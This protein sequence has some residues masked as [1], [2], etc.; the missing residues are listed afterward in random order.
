MTALPRLAAPALTHAAGVMPV[1]VVTGARQTGKTTLVRDIAPTGER[2]YFT[3]DDLDVLEQA[4]R[5]PDDLVG[6]AER[7]TLDEVQRAP[8]LLLAVKRAVDRRRRAGRFLLTGSANLLLMHRISETLAGRA[9]YL[10]LWPMTRREQLGMGRGGIWQELLDAK[11][12]DWPDVVA[13]QRIGREDWQALARRGGY[14]VPAL[15]LNSDDARAT[16]FAGYVQTYL[17]RDLRDLSVVTSLPDVRR[18]MR[19]ICLRL[20]QL[21]NQTELGRDVTLPQPTVHR[22]LNLLE[23]SYQLVRVPAYA[24]NRTKRVIKT[25]KVYWADT[26]LALHV[27]GL[28]EPGGPHLENLVLSDLL[29]WRDVRLDRPEVLYWRTATGE[30]VDFVIEAGRTLLPIEVKSTARPRPDDA[31][32]LLVFREE[33]RRRCRPGLLVHTGDAIEWLAAGVLAAPWWKVL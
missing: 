2:P 19:A 33:Y 30:E 9:S 17:E 28:A 3:L 23:T 26:A 8:Q 6:R 29:A 25:A 27:A 11:D 24:V 18:L 12:E 32:H 1:I 15:D 13:A 31:K 10:T 16:W 22:W 4:G 21:L 14:P 7:L 5:A 20:G